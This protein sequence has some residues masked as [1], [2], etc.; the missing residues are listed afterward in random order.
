MLLPPQ[1]AE[2]PVLSA[3]SPW[4]C[5]KFWKSWKSL[6]AV[7]V[8]MRPGLK[9]GVLVLAVSSVASLFPFE[10]ESS[11][12]SWL[13]HSCLPIYKYQRNTLIGQSNLFLYMFRRCLRQEQIF[14]FLFFL[15]LIVI[16][17]IKLLTIYVFTFNHYRPNFQ[18][19]VA[20][21][22]SGWTGLSQIIPLGSGNKLKSGS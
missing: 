16:Y 6:F 20:R 1:A 19:I 17:K 11:G 7:T 5:M 4:E 10:I 14:Y 21:S 13:W 18:L 9:S 22:I 3:A 12:P 15:L 2:L 8:S